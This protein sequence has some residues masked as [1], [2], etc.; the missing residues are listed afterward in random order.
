MSSLKIHV[1]FSVTEKGAGVFVCS[2]WLI[3]S[4]D[5]CPHFLELFGECAFSYFWANAHFRKLGFK[6]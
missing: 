4:N 6:F 3:G 1:E 5:F 2:D